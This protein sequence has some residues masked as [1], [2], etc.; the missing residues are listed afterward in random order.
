MKRNKFCIKSRSDIM[1]EFPGKLYT[2]WIKYVG[3][4]NIILQEKSLIE[5]KKR[6]L[7]KNTEKE[8]KIEWD[9]MTSIINYLRE[10]WF[11]FVTLP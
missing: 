3:E 4:S 1:R 6:D 9:S 7:K 10:T 11:P 2:S 5:H 8:C